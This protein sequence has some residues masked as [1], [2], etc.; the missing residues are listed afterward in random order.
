MK[1]YLLFYG[2][3]YYPSGGMDDFLTDCDSIEECLIEYEK[4]ILKDYIEK[5]SIYDSK[6]E[7]IKF[8][9][10]YYWMHI[11][12]TKERIKTLEK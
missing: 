9:E 2:A 4:E 6:E 8:N 3:N 7:Y 11:Y 5:Y 12:D 10:Q 1:R